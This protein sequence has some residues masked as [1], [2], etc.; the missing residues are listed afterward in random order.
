MKEWKLELQSD[1]LRVVRHS[2]WALAGGGFRTA[3]DR[4]FFKAN[5]GHHAKQLF[6]RLQSWGP[7]LAPQLWFG[8]DTY[9]QDASFWK[10]PPARSVVGLCS[11]DL[12]YIRLKFRLSLPPEVFQIV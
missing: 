3:N 7:V 1:F 11:D 5:A 6:Q 4:T 10:S 12:C 9:L 8:L 2:A